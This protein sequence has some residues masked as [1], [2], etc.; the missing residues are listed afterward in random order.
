MVENEKSSL[1][2]YVDKEWEIIPADKTYKLFEGQMKRIGHL[3]N[4]YKQKQL[5]GLARARITP[6]GYCN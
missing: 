6:V 2:S 5:E 3:I 4:Y 1:D